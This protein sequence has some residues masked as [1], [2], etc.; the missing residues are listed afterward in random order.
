MTVTDQILHTT[1]FIKIAEYEKESAN[2][3]EDILLSFIGLFLSFPCSQSLYVLSHKI[4]LHLHIV[5]WIPLAENI[6]LP[7]DEEKKGRN[8]CLRITRIYASQQDDGIL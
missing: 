2:I 4:S 8:S 3:K 6:L 7:L 1:V 5:D